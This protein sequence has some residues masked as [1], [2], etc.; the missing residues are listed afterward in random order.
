LVNPRSQLNVANSKL[1]LSL[2]SGMALKTL[3]KVGRISNLSDARYCAGMAVDMLGFRVIAGQDHYVSPELFKE[4]R[5]WFS[6]PAIVAEAYGIEKSEDLPVLIQSYLPDFIELSLTDL[7]KI[8]SPYS[9]YI[10]STTYEELVA[11]EAVLAPYRIQISKVILPA[12]TDRKAIDE[13]ARNYKVLLQVDSNT[14]DDVFINN[15][16]LKGIALQGSPE[17]KPGLKNYDQL[18]DILEKLEV[19]N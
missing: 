2:K 15:A 14:P 19:D 4:I 11:Q 6:G 18:A 3:V 10:L 13:L 9:T 1:I 8:H 16:S 5:G 12:S 7:L 17:E